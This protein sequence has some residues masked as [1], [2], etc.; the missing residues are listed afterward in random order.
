M[1]FVSVRGT[2]FRDLLC[3]LTGPVEANTPCNSISCLPGSSPEDASKSAY[4]FIQAYVCIGKSYMGLVDAAM[5][6][7]MVILRAHCNAFCGLEHPWTRE[8]LF[9]PHPQPFFPGMSVFLGWTKS[10]AI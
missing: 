2:S 4:G 9:Q 7:M 10:A 6:I 3:F 5:M 1:D 8:H